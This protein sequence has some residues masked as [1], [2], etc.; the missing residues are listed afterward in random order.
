[1]YYDNQ[2]RPSGFGYLPVVTKNII[3]INA[4]MYLA[5]I[6]LANVGINLYK[7]L[8]LHYHLAPDFKPHQFIT[9][10]FMHDMNGISHIL[11]NMLGVF[12]FGQVLENTWGPKRFLIFY[13]VSG[14]GAAA[15]HYVVMHF[16][17]QEVLELYGTPVALNGMTAVGA[18]GCLMGLLG[19]FGM[20]F[21]NRYIYVYFL[22][23]IK[24]KWFVIIYGA[25]ELL[26]GMHNV[27]NIAHFAH[28]G[29]L[30]AGVIMVLIWRRDRRNFY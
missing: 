6:L 12:L 1:M 20:L 16:Q 11:F 18:S 9:H 29:G 5:T 27:G 7:Y 25:A 24:A 14:L 3:I 2:Y 4:I 21:P 19:A 8:A 28:V 10:M 15:A 26:Q 23:P 22:F 17:A 30:V 13:M